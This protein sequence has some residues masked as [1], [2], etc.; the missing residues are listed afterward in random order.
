MPLRSKEQAFR[1]FKAG[2][3]HSGKG[4]PVVTSRKQATAI[5]LS[6]ERRMKRRGRG[7]SMGGRH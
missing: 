5:A 6:T 3:L 7:R 1:E 4:G 2:T